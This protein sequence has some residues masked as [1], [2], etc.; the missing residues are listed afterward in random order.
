LGR[1]LQHIAHDALVVRRIC[2]YHPR[3][4]QRLAD[5]ADNAIERAFHGECFQKKDRA[6][7]PNYGLSQL[8]VFKGFYAMLARV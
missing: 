2:R 5:E 4:I 8:S 7:L 1:P 3:R 6:N